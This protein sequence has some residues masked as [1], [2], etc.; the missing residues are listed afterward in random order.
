VAESGPS[1][2]AAAATRQEQ[3][4]IE[5]RNV[6]MRL[7]SARKWN[8]ERDNRGAVHELDFAIGATLSLRSA[9]QDYDKAVGREPSV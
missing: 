3:V 9:V 7:D 1:S 8:A 6:L 4:V 5:A 2:N